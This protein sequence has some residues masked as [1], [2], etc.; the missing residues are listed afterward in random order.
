[1]V[2]VSR[3][4]V[5]RVEHRLIVRENIW[6]RVSCSSLRIYEGLRSAWV[7]SWAVVALVVLC[8]PICARWR[9]C[10]SLGMGTE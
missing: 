8:C 2:F 3:A 6:V 5:P 7:D 4:V 9:P 1:M 10:E